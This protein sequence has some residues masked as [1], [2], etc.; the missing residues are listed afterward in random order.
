MKYETKQKIKAFAA[1]FAVAGGI[2]GALAGAQCWLIRN[3]PYSYR[4]SGWRTL[5]EYFTDRD[6]KIWLF[7]QH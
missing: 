4:T 1:G 5:I 3:V 7:R 6:G 2:A